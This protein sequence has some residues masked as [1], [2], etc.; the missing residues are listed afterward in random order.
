[1]KMSC[2]VG[3]KG[4]GRKLFAGIC[5]SVFTSRMFVYPHPQRMYFLAGERGQDEEQRFPELSTS[6]SVPASAD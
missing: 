2:G 6:G 3:R 5:D 4:R 1:M